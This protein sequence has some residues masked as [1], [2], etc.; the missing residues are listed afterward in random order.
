MPEIVTPYLTFPNICWWME[1]VKCEQLLFDGGEHF[2]KMSLRNRYRISGA[3]NPILLS[4][5]L[6]N[7]RDQRSPMNEIR[8]YNEKRWQVQHWRT[9]VSVYKRSPFF[10]YYEDS[11]RELYE[12]RFELLTE[13]NLAGISWIRKQLR[14]TFNVSE[15]REFV[16][17]Y[18]DGIIDI[19][20]K[21]YDG[22]K[23]PKYYQVF[24]DRIGF[25]PDLS[26][27]DLLFC[28]GPASVTILRG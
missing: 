1:V 15:T 6:V 11:L 4:I 2:Q 12:T 25:L 18:S 21:K 24:E 20:Q 7:G 22:S 14:L 16:Q 27:L 28:E 10:D 26:I 23:V 5:P 3:N 19:R 9:L 17:D 13:F 8:I